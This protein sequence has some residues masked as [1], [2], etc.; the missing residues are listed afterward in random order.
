MKLVLDILSQARALMLD[1][2]PIWVSRDNPFLLKADAI[3]KGIDSD[4]WESVQTDFANLEA[5]FGPFL[6][7]LF[8]VGENA[9][10]EQFYTRS[11]EKGSAGVDAFSQSWSGEKA[12]TDP[13]VSLVMRTIRKMAITVMKGVLIIPLWKNA[14][15]WTFAFRDG[16]HLNAMFDLV[17]IVRMHTSAWEFSKKDIIGGKE[18]Q[19]LVFDLGNVRGEQAL[20]SLLGT[21]RCFQRLFGRDCKVC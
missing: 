6:I 13:P 3:S 5:C 18:I 19:F 7:D 12:Y 14:K 10:C 21:G 2:Q 20:E 9:Q 17:P 8:A 4:N 1:I 16:I 11:W 15:F